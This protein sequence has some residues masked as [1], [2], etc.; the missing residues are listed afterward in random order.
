MNIESFSHD[1]LEWS[2][3]N[4]RSFP[5][6]QEDATPYEVLI[7]EIFLKQTRASV[8]ADAYPEFIGKFPN[9]KALEEGDRDKIIS[10]IRPL[11]LYNNRADALLE[12][13]E[14]IG[15]DGIPN[16]FG[17]LLALPQVGPYVANATMC[18]GFGEDR[19][20]VDGNIQRIFGRLFE[21]EADAL[22]LEEAWQVGKKHLPKECVRRYNLALLDFGAM[23]CTDS[24][25]NCSDCFAQN[26]C[27]YALRENDHSA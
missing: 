13:G 4:L 16:S 10:I 14:A 21:G 9:V 1:L 17:E 22:P 26:Y 5:W 23:V 18:F 27:E 20:I 11:G 15:D 8:V 25:P 12:I 3:G 6:R 24:S 19:A 7:A 2:Q